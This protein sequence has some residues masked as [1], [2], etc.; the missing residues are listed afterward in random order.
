[1]GKRNHIPT[2]DFGTHLAT[3]CGVFP[4][5]IEECMG[6]SGGVCLNCRKQFL[7]TPEQI[8]AYSTA[9]QRQGESFN[10]SKQPLPCPTHPDMLVA[11][12]NGGCWKC[13]EEVRRTEQ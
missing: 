8:N 6:N 11:P 5:T 12:G 9:L 13:G 10:F 2:N 4:R 1:M 7:R 3:L